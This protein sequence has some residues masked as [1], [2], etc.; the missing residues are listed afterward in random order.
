M[1]ENLP[2][3]IGQIAWVCFLALVFARARILAESQELLNLLYT[4]HVY[5]YY[6]IDD[7]P[8]NA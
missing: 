5:H 3:H 4:A 7:L 2:I 6:D 8:R 1:L